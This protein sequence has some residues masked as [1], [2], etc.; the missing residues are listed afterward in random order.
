M[1]QEFKAQIQEA[2]SRRHLRLQD[3][4]EAMGVSTGY[5]SRVWNDPEE[6]IS[7]AAI[8]KICAGIGI[9]PT[10]IDLYVEKML[11]FL[12]RESTSLTNLGRDLLK[13][14]RANRKVKPRKTA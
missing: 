6:D 2:M 11:P 3:V 8:E 5:V 14:Q 10:D 1:R 7:L 9:D 12:A 4:A 13:A